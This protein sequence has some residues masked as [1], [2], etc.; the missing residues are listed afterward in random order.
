MF[1]K[2]PDHLS[3]KFLNGLS[4]QAKGR[5][6]WFFAFIA[7]LM[8]QFFVISK[9]ES[10]LENGEKILIPYNIATSSE[11]I[12]FSSDYSE[13]TN[14][15]ML[16]A[17]ADVIL[18]GNTRPDN[19]T[20]IKQK[21]LK[22]FHPDLYRQAK[23]EELKMANSDK[24]REVTRSFD[25]EETYIDRKGR[26]RVDGISYIDVAGVKGPALKESVIVSYKK[27]SSGYPY[28]IGWEKVRT[29]GINK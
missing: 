16:I 2:R 6:A 28:I 25:I 24:L 27:G 10:S 4:E 18:W 23:D 20:G 14:Y 5:S 22:R 19:V 3:S 11:E 12:N 9:L 29:E 17:E 8:Y 21:F 13:G 26:I 7:L 1:S 15:I